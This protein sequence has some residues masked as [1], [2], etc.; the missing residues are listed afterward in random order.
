MTVLSI[1]QRV[2]PKIGLEYPDELY[3]SVIREFEELRDVMEDMATRITEGHEWQLLSKVGT[4]TGDGSTTAWDLPSDYDRM[5]QDSQVWSDSLE[6]PLTHLTSLNEW[7]GLDIQSF[8]FVINAWTIY[9]GQMYITPALANGVTAQFFYQSNLT[10]VEDDGTTFKTVS[11]V[12]SDSFRLDEGLLKLGTIWRWKSYK[13]QTYAEEL[14]D[15]EEKKER[16]V[17]RDKGARSLRLGRIR[18][19]NDVQIAYPQTITP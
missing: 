5:V 11:D 1:A 10:F 19:P 9:G 4:I 3:P 14:E 6:T 15:Y 2:T 16:L 13:G 12:D 8:D 7:L 18:L 17:V